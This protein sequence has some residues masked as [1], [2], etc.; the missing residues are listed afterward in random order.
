ML[1][2]FGS[3]LFVWIPI[4]FIRET[5]FWELEDLELQFIKEFRPKLNFP[6]VLRHIHE[7]VDAQQNYVKGA[8][9]KQKKIF[10]RRA[11]H[12]PP[13]QSRC[14]KVVGVKDN[15]TDTLARSQSF[16][17][18]ALRMGDQRRK[19]NKCCGIVRIIHRDRPWILPLLVGQILKRLSAPQ[20]KVAM[21]RL[22]SA[23]REAWDERPPV[24][25]FSVLNLPSLDVRKLLVD[26]LMP[27][28]A[29]N[30]ARNSAMIL[31]SR[32]KQFSSI[33]R[34]LSNSSRWRSS[35]DIQVQ[36]CTC[37][38]MRKQLCLPKLEPGQHYSVR[39]RDTCFSAYFPERCSADTIILPDKAS[40]LHSISQ[41]V[42]HVLARINSLDDFDASSLVLAISNWYE[43]CKNQYIHESDILKLKRRL[44]DCCVVSA[45]DKSKCDLALTCPQ[46]HQFKLMQAFIDGKSIQTDYCKEIVIKSFQDMRSKLC[47]SGI[48]IPLRTH[49]FGAAD[50]IP[51][52]S[53]LVE[54]CRPLGSYKRHAG[55][56]ALSVSCKCINF[57]L[58]SIFRQHKCGILVGSVRA[59]R[60]RCFEHNLWCSSAINS[61][62]VGCTFRAKFDVDGFFNAVPWNL[63]F[64]A[65]DW[66]KE[67]CAVIFG[68]K[69]YFAIPRQKVRHSPPKVWTRTSG[70][71]IRGSYCDG[72]DVRRPYATTSR[73]VSGFFYLLDRD[74][75]G[76]ILIWDVLEVGWLRFGSSLFKPLHKALTQGSP[77]APG[78]CIAT[79]CF[80]E[81]ENAHVFR[82]NLRFA[83]SLCMR[84]VDDLYLIF[85]IFAEV[86]D[87]QAHVAQGRALHFFDDIIGVYR[88]HF[89]MKEEDFQSFVG[90]DVALESDSLLTLKP[91]LEADKWKLQHRIT[92][93]PRRSI[94]RNLMGQ[95]CCLADRCLRSDFG[96][97]L[98]RFLDHCRS[99]GYDDAILKSAIYAFLRRHPYLR[100]DCHRGLALA[101]YL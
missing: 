53:G 8:Q 13:L 17:L 92:A 76:E 89:G 62:R 84:W 2:Q 23:T 10:K 42:Q 58:A 38:L 100:H 43:R 51:K 64:R 78:A 39:L 11:F 19:A 40:V 46:L 27:F 6:H 99:L 26:L 67:Q 63:F 36:E 96:V 68:R 55:R 87:A 61:G 85:T 44:N 48:N 70:S 28:V 31:N 18:L 52:A 90:M 21:G 91:S 86:K 57:G 97:S 72:S 66:F 71:G 54:K 20:R 59:V 37:R 95:F 101:G 60:D 35:M 75:V 25:R 69:R 82:T 74:H 77:G 56:T 3:H 93:K 24:I 33:K 16:A 50:I 4:A 29:A 45:L 98:G 49:L 32:P 47:Y 34:L 12:M 1:R 7:D 9:S 14:M 83:Q 22:S 80:I 88:L 73:K 79:L 5:Y 41:A 81:W 15:L 30:I 94:M 65:M